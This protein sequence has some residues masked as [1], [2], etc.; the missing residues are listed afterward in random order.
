MFR[1]ILVA[2]DGSETAQ[3]ALEAAA[4]L[5]EALNSRL[6]VIAVAPQVPP[7]AYRAGVDVGALEEEASKE[8]EKLLRKA[9]ESLPEELPVTTVMKHGHA[10]ERIVEQLRSGQHDLLA[11]AR[12]VADVW[13]RA[14]SGASA[15]TCTTTRGSRCS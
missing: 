5:A 8:T 10:G 11:M 14:C 1:D 3:R 13:R 4:E 2:I 9:V 12:A 7:Y 15:P 6:T